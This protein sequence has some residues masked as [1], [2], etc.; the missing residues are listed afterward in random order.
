MNIRFL[1]IAEI[2]L[3]EAIEYYE[4]EARGLGDIF[5]QE[6]LNSLDRISKFPHAWH[7]CSKRSRRC[8]TK[9][10]PYGIIYQTRGNEILVV[11]VANLHRKPDY[12]ADRL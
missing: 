5:L 3:K 8:R 12:W 11:A 4:Y 1:E 10:F 6:V 7:P 2:E 9:K